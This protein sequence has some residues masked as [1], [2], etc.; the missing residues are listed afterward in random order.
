MSDSDCTS[1]DESCYEFITMYQPGHTDGHNRFFNG[2]LYESKEAADFASKSMNS[3]YCVD[4][5]AVSCIRL[6]R[7]VVYMI[8]GPYKTFRDVEMEEEIRNAALAK[9]SDVEKRVL[10]LNQSPGEH[11]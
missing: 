4:S 3:V 2:P 11:R 6:K 1:C 9:L 7:G 5:R 8:E 10:G